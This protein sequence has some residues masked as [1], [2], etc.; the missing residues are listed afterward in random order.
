[1]ASGAGAGTATPASPATAGDEALAVALQAA[2]E[3]AAQRQFTRHAGGA[4]PSGE[5]P[6]GVNADIKPPGKRE[7]KQGYHFAFNHL[8]WDRK[9][10]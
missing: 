8:L 1:M 6:F 10:F 4:G 5:G 9:A 7:R 2:E 3:V